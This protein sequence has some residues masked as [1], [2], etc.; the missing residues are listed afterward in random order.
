M[1]TSCSRIIEPSVQMLKHRFQCWGRT[2]SKNAYLFVAQVWSELGGFRQTDR[3][4]EFTFWIYEDSEILRLSACGHQYIE[5]VSI[6]LLV[7]MQM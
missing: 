6:R 3:Q 5:G 4:T 1:G 2:H 7:N